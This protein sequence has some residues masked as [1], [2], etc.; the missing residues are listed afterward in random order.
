MNFAV[1]WKPAAIRQ[2][3]DA[4]LAGRR[5]GRGRAVT[6]AA[7]RMEAALARDPLAVGESRPGRTRVL[8]DVPLVVSYTVRTQSQEVFIL[9]VRY[10]R[11][12]RP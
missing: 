8:P 11:P 2:L 10:A 12:R 4:Y 3:A 5:A 9:G 6:N 7:A 1:I